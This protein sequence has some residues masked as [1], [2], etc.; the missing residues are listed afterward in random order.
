MKA[1]CS[2]LDVLGVTPFLQVSLRYIT[3]PSGANP[4]QK[5]HLYSHWCLGGG[6]GAFR[7]LSVFPQSENLGG[8]WGVWSVKCVSPE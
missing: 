4:R 5:H 1:Q 2:V 6:V 8:S 3:D 7:V